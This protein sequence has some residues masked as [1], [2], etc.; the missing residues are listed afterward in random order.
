MRFT[1][2]LRGPAVFKARREADTLEPGHYVSLDG[3]QIE[4][5]QEGIILDA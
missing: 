5:L 1:H 4:L 3:L 2:S